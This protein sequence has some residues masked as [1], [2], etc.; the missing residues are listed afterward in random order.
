MSSILDSLTSQIGGTELGQLANI[1]GVNQHQTQSAVPAAVGALLGA[2]GGN[3]ARRDGAD[4]LHRALGKDHDGS[5]LDNLG[6]FLGGGQTG[7]GEAILG[8]VLGGRQATVENELS[9]ST[10]LDS[11]SIAK[12]LTML[13]PMVLAY[14]GKQQ[15]QKG[16]DSGGLAELLGRERQ[17]L[18]QQPPA[19]LGILG[20]LLDQDGDGDVKDDLAKAGVGILGK[21]FSRR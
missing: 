12:L 4:S 11:R 18:R 21:L 13:A 14:L 16:L 15:R 6:G 1:L 8:H 7:I 17:Q 19:N 20:A 10:G 9:K 2:L 5:L 3:A